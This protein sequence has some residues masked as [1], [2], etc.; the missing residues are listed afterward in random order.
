MSPDPRSDAELIVAYRA[1]EEMAFTYLVVRYLGDLYRFL[2]HLTG[3]RHFAEDLC[4]ETFLK[5]WKHLERFDIKKSFKP[6][7]FTIAHHA[8]IDYLRKQRPTPFAMLEREDLSDFGA[9][10]PDQQD[11]PDV[12]LAHKDLAKILEQGLA[13]LPFNTRSTVLLHQ[14]EGLTFQEIADAMQEPLN[15]VKSRYRRALSTLKQYLTDKI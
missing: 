5:A 7:V 13:V 8:A 15:T 11:L 10:I 9:T 3:D 6:W 1:G 12:L 2:V 4:Q 14:Q